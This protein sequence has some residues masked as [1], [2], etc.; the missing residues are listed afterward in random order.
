[1]CGAELDSGERVGGVRRC[2]RE[3]VR[4]AGAPAAARGNSRGT[5]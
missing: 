3:E 2:I 1:M 5:V 4:S